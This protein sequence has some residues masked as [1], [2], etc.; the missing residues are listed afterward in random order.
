[1]AALVFLVASPVMGTMLG[2]DF[3]MDNINLGQV[4]IPGFQG[5]Q[6]QFPSAHVT[7]V[8]C[9][10][11]LGNCTGPSLVLP[12]SFSAQCVTA[13]TIKGGGCRVCCATG[14]RYVH[15]TE[16]NPIGSCTPAPPPP[17]YAILPRIHPYTC[18]QTA[19]E[20][21]QTGNKGAFCYF[22]PCWPPR[23]D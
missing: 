7:S 22:T 3:D 9:S 17:R 12:D 2:E 15:A 13:C 16:N 18:M 10:T 1:M 14:Y 23:D 5:S 4:S 20:C 21:K 6:K 19:K 8:T 11:D